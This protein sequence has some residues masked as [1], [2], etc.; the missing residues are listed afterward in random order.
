MDWQECYRGR[1][2]LVTGHSGFKGTWMT[3]W[4]E[5]LGARV[6]GFSLPPTGDRRSMA[7]GGAP[8]NVESI[9]GDVRDRDAVARSVA[10]RRPEIVFHLAAQALVRRSYAEPVET[11]D[12]NV[13]GTV[14]VL[15]AARRCDSVRAVVVVTSDKCYENREWV[16]PYRETDP[17]GGHDPYSSSKGCAE[18]VTSSYRASFCGNDESPSIASVR[19]GNVIGGG[20]W[21]EDRLVPDVVRAIE[22]GRQ[23]EIRSPHAIRPWQHVLEPLAGYLALGGRLLEAGDQFA[24]AWNFGPNPESHLTVGKFV[25]RV[26]AEWGAGR[27]VHRADAGERHEATFLALDSSK[28]RARLGWRP[29]LDVNDAVAWTVDWYRRFLAGSAS[30][31]SLIDEQI[32]S[33]EGLLRRGS[34]RLAA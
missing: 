3:R 30:A 14:N 8:A 17:M 33:Y 34:K 18:L 25:E 5:A 26:T 4:L 24:E 23:V 11:F 20:D 19:A 2:V 12:T 1:T 7:A 29:V 32:A 13:M 6:V 28:S 16:W 27:F 9:R 22:R 21:A 31:E 10:T 15:D